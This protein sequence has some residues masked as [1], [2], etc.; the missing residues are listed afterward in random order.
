M[1]KS[2]LKVNDEAWRRI[3]RQVLA[4]AARGRGVKVGVMAAAGAPGDLL[5]IAAVHEYGSPRR[6][7]PERSFIRRTF[8][9]KKRQLD[10]V[11]TKVARAI[12]KDRMSVDTGLNVIG[13]W[14]ATQVKH[15][16]AS[17][18]HIPPPL[19]PETIRR[20]GSDRP[21]VDTGRLLNSITWVVE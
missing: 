19:Q 16:I 7:I 18:P 1:A 6:N 20:K 3:Q 2:S 13:V 12:L 4:I 5:L 17:G 9:E 8:R 14:M 10:V 11:V 15:T 21:L